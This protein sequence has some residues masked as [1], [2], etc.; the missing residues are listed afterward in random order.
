MKKTLIYAVVAMVLAVSGLTSG[1]VGVVDPDAFPAGTVLNNA[2]TGVT[3]T[4]LG[5]PG[6]LLNSDVVARASTYASTGS[7]VFGDNEPGNLDSWGDGSYDYL[8][9]DF[10][11]GATTTL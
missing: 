4:A 11:I 3:L 2:Y 6:V 8:R 1:S 10:A 5:D 7:N 9:V